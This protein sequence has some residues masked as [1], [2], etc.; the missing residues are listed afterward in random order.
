LF[1][2]LSKKRSLFE[3]CG[4]AALA[5]LAAAWVVPYSSSAE[6]SRFSSSPSSPQFSL[7][8]ASR[9]LTLRNVGLAQLEEDRPKEARATFAKLAE[10]LPGEPLPLANGAIAALREKDL[11][12]AEALLGKA[13]AL[14][15]RADLYAILAA[16]ENE[17][18][19]P[20]AARAALEKAAAL[21]PRDLESRWRFARSVETDPSGTPAEK[22][23]RRARLAEIVAR[24]PSNLPARLKL[25]VLE[26]DAGDAAA[27]AKGLLELDPLVSDGDARARQ[28]LSE[29]KALAGTG[30]VRG[31]TVKVRVL[32]NLLRVT[33]RYQQSL[34]EMFTPVVGLPLP[35]FSPAVEQGLRAKGGTA[36]PVTLRAPVPSEESPGSILRR[37]DL[38]N[39]GTPELYSVPAPFTGAVFFDYDLDGDLDLVMTNGV[40]YPDATSDDPYHADPMRLWRNDGGGAWTE[41]AAAE[42]IT[43]TR[44]GKGLLVFDYDADGDLDVF[45]V[46]NAS[47]PVLYQNQTI[48]PGGPHWLRVRAVDAHGSDALGATVTAKPVGGS[49]QMRVIGSATHFLAWSDPAAHFGLGASTADVDL[50]VRW[51]GG[52]T[53]TRR[54]A[55][56]ALD[57]TLVVPEP[58]APIGCVLATLAAIALRR[59]SRADFTGVLG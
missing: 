10:A 16:I 9:I 39:S 23:A 45:V 4:W 5:V 34:A 44:S 6:N 27:L 15:D 41:V 57:R 47:T 25:L 37:V 11:T 56:D 24:S 26:G 12:G 58:R 19:R 2:F 29:G 18:N 38:K 54:I 17:K 48:A 13:L 33:P 43:D 53:S 59:R 20:A 51:P 42:G 50:T 14:G 36:V 1:N 46:N 35:A 7:E 49:S 3:R 21:G 55:G 8:Q 31:A 30:D 22:A 28:F 52:A 32:E 40:D